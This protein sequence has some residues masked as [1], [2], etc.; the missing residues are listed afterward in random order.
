[1]PLKYQHYLKSYSR[2]LRNNSTLGEILLWNELK[3]RKIH[4]YQFY[5]QKP[6]FNYIADFYCPALKLII[7]LDGKYH[8]QGE[9]QVADDIRQHRLETAGIHFVRFTEE[10]VKIKLQSVLGQ[11]E[12][13]IY[14]FVQSRNQS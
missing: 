13:Y 14:G 7:E 12:E 3:Q 5:R 4:G 9:Q 10:E 6:I 11:I 2:S 8:N 1:M